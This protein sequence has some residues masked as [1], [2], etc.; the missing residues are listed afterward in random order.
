MDRIPIKTIIT[1]KQHST[2]KLNIQIFLKKVLGLKHKYIYIVFQ[3]ALVGKW[4]QI[5]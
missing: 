2:P 3:K 5:C 1:I 4:F